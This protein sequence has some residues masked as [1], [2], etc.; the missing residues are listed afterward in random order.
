[1]VRRCTCAVN[2]KWTDLG[3]ECLLVDGMDVNEVLEGY[4]VKRVVLMLVGGSDLDGAVLGPHEEAA[5][6]ANDSVLA[7]TL[8]HYTD[9]RYDPSNIYATLVLAAT[10]SLALENSFD[11][12]HE[13]RYN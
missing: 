1:M 8:P 5:E 12:T 2:Y 11:M 10:S 9:L 6:G 4:F 3:P 13:Y 7:T